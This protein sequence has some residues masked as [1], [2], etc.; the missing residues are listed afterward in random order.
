MILEAKLK[1]HS[2]CKSQVKQIFGKYFDK[3]K[4]D[5]SLTLA[6][7][8]VIK[9]ERISKTA[10][11]PHVKSLNENDGTVRPPLESNCRYGQ[12][13]ILLVSV[14]SIDLQ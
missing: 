3:T 11:H 1:P 12:I 4:L 7:C 9:F 8:L 2:L 6:P 14:A 13:T 10:K 5:M